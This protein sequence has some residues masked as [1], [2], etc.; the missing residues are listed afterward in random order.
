MDD[1]SAD[2]PPP[3]PWSGASSIAD[4]DLDDLDR[5]APV[6]LTT[7]LPARLVGSVD[8][9]LDRDLDGH[10]WCQLLAAAACHDAYRGDPR[11]LALFE[12]AWAA[13]EAA[14]DDEAL[15]VAANVRANI[16]LGH[17][18]IPGAVGWWRRAEALLGRQSDIAISAA[19]HGSLDCLRQGRSGRGRAAGPRCAAARR[20]RREPGRLHHAARLPGLL[21]LLPR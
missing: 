2:L 4:A 7:G 12:A 21:R 17:G 8:E 3:P 11:A 14:G 1:T 20:C 15:G 6:A 10:P 9:L 16:A 5:L 13:F 19:A 18:D